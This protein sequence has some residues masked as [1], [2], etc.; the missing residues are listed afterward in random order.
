PKCQQLAV[1]IS[2]KFCRSDGSLLVEDS[3]TEPATLLRNVGDHSRSITKELTEPTSS[4]AVLPFR[5]LSPDPPHDY[6]SVGLAEELVHA[7][8]RIENLRVA[9]PSSAS[10]KEKN[11]AAPEIG[12]TLN[13]E[14]VLEGSIRR[15]ESK[16]RITV[17]LV[18]TKTGYHLWSERYDRNVNDTFDLRGDI[19]FAV[20]KALAVRLGGRERVA[21]RKRYTENHV[22][23]QLYLRGRFYAGRFTA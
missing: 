8:S 6:F 16:M 19:A 23:H 1:E 3:L 21:V 22:A 12:K 20:L 9:A 7:L 10:L 14:A 5:N 15:S 13:V 2:L 11:L 18:S 17:Q 4:L